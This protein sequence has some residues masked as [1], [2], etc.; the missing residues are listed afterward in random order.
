MMG[1]KLDG[2]TLKRKSFEPLAKS[3]EN[4][5]KLDEL[6]LEVDNLFG[7]NNITSY[8]I[9]LLLGGLKR[10]PIRKLRLCM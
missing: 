4:L 7:N 2:C 3:L 1:L 6:A 10:I 5:I 9:G 8:G